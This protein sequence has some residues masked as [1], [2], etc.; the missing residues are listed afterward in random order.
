M[1][2]PPVVRRAQRTLEMAVAFGKISP[3]WDKEA[4]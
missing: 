2:D 3:D 1:I 4:E